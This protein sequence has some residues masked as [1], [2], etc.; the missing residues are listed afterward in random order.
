MLEAENKSIIC[1]TGQDPV[2]TI[3][4]VAAERF[5]FIAHESAIKSFVMSLSCKS[6]NW[7]YVH[8]LERS[9]WKSSFALS[10]SH[11]T[12]KVSAALKEIQHF[13]N[14]DGVGSFLCSSRI[15]NVD[16]ITLESTMKATSRALLS[17]LLDSHDSFFLVKTAWC[18]WTTT[19]ALFRQ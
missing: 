14:V 1:G 5:V 13:K 18:Q 4:S 9:R 19:V 12:F 11:V 8:D 2:K 10:C 3:C 6:L 7:K 15:W 16:I 17:N